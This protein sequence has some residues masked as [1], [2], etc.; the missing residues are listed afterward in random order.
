MQVCFPIVQQVRETHKTSLLKRDDVLHKCTA[1]TFTKKHLFHW[2]SYLAS[3]KKD[4]AQEEWNEWKI[5]INLFSLQEKKPFRGTDQAAFLLFTPASAFT[6]LLLFVLQSWILV[7]S[8]PWKGFFF[9]YLKIFES[10][11]CNGVS[12]SQEPCASLIGVSDIKISDVQPGVICLFRRFLT[13]SLPLM[14]YN[15][16]TVQIRSEIS[17]S[18][19]LQYCLQD[20][21]HMHK[22][23]VF[24][25][26]AAQAD[27]FFSL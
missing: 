27:F 2:F 19:V 13:A 10:M 18:L 22:G 16:E 5:E 12:I 20:F 21:L 7:Y 3:L 15:K 24:A 14:A 4:Q 26:K 8:S 11:L 6:A 23:A 1:H 17:G 9:L 25:Y